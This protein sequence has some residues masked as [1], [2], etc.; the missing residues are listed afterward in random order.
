VPA[1]AV[2]AKT[3]E[4]IRDALMEKFIAGTILQLVNVDLFGEGTDVPAVEVVSMGRPTESL[5]LYMQQFGRALRVLPGKS[6][7]TIIDHV[8]NVARHGLPDQVRS[9]SLIAEERGKRRERDPEAVP[10]TT[11]PECFQAYEATTAACPFCGHRPEPEG[12]SRPEFVDGDLVELDE[13]TLAAMRGTVA[14]IDAPCPIDVVDAR[15][16]AM[17][18]NWARRQEAQRELRDMMAIWAGL[19]RNLGRDDSEIYRR[20]YHAFG[21]DMLT[22][23]TMGTPEAHDLLERIKSFRFEVAK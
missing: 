5:G 12:R 22:A 4:A 6:H 16:G 7:G 15:T 9:W 18:K 2:S 23:Q 1:A 13:A 11:C 8:G 3:P 19:Q 10:V 20:F 17:R 21:I 14:E